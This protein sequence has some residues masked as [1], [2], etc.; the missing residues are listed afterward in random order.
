MK[1]SFI[2]LDYDYFEIN[3]DLYIKIYGRT[4]NGE[5]CCLIDK[6]DYYFYI[7]SSSPDKIIEKIKEIP[8]VKKVEIVKKKF[9]EK[10]VDAI[11]IYC[12]HTKT[13][14]IKEK[15]KKFDP[16]IKS[17]ERDISVISKY[18][19]DK[20]IKP[21]FFYKIEIEVLGKEDFYGISQNL[22][23]DIVGIIKKIELE[24]EFDFK[25][26]TLALD[27]ETDD[28]EI[29]RGE[30]LMISLV[31]ENFK[32]VLTW[33]YKS[34]KDF[35]EYCKNEA[36][37]LE[38]F[39]YYVK[40]IDPD[41]IVTYFGDGFDM[42]YIRER[43]EKNKVD[44]RIGRDKSKILFLKGVERS[45][46]IKGI[47]HID[48][49]NFIQTVYSQYLQSETLSLNEVARE[50]IGET[51]I[52]FEKEDIGKNNKNIEEKDWEK[53]FDYNL[54]DSILTYKLFNKLWPDIQEFT[55]IIHEPL[56]N[57]TRYTISHLV[58]NYIIHHLYKFNEIAERR[59]LHDE[60]EQ[61][62]KREKYEGGFVLQPKPGLYENIAFFD[63]TSMYP[64]I[65]VSFN[66]SLPTL[67][68]KKE[69]DCYEVDIGNKKVYF[70]K[71]EGFLPK[72][73]N[74]LIN[75]RK[76]YKK[77]SKEKKDPITKARS[78]A[79]KL[80]TNAFYGYYG[81]FGARYYCVE[82]AAAVAALAK[83][84]IK[85]TIERVRKE[86][87]EIIY[88]D[89]DGFAFSLKKHTK[90]DVLNLLKEINKKLPGIME[91][92]LEDFYKRGLWVTKRTG[93][94][95]AKKKYALINYEG[96]IK[97]RGFETVRRDWCEL[98][99]ETQNN[100]IKMILE[101]GN[102]KDA[103]NYIKEI[104][105]KIKERKIEKKKLLIKT[106]LKKPLREY[107]AESPH[108]TIA[109]KMLERGYP[110]DVGML[111]V[112]YIAEAR[113]EKLVR[114]RAK[115]PEEE[116]D[117]DIN[118]YINHQLLPAVENI[119]EIFGLDIKEIFKE[120]LEGKKQKRLVEF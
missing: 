41:I 78:N 118:Y 97:I 102:E 10:S 29:G 17:K 45:A 3:D 38:K 98:A 88:A 28:F 75:L 108:V 37:M 99:R 80:L 105:K 23:V 111:I 76:K 74:D 59:P 9:L 1:I 79:F 55:K 67:L 42:P 84:L 26:K 56:F 66:I 36:D 11:K 115:L 61:R 85:E 21:L 120:I 44:L 60:I 90:K 24:K 96:K 30:I 13:H 83:K 69:K 70:S 43:A 94:I 104:I 117:Y 33:K 106:Q 58:E 27:I 119:F 5:S 87:Y 93:E 68:Q 12:K 32:K 50:L 25:P 63:F 71:K 31:G 62:K 54:Q 82:A 100:V 8:E 7:L 4:K 73:L 107:K 91:L 6:Y 109:K 112:Y 35:V 95:G 86:D 64:S 51:K 101:K 65:I 72:L 77:E 116:D 19:I 52:E 15:I 18:I 39:L 57:V 40:K 20:K 14:D 53:Y 48:L 92:E 110:V 2:P 49:I 89:T 34:K 113:G 46:K 114:E 81:F 103:I 16:E 22:E 47:V